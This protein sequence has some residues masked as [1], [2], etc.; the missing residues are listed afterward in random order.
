MTS[1]DE[2]LNSGIRNLLQEYARSI[3]IHTD[4]RDYDD[5]RCY[6]AVEDEFLEFR[7]AM[8]TGDKDGPHGMVNESLQLAVVALKA[9]IKYV[10]G[11]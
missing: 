2:R 5:E 10:N 9:H 7:R 4:W 11:E 1:D 8:I 6:T 3:Q